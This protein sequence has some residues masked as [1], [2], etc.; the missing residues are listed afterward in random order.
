[1]PKARIP[2]EM[3]INNMSVNA[4]QNLIDCP[5][6]FFL[7]DILKLKSLDT[8][9]N[10]GT[11]SY[12]NFAHKVLEIFHNQNNSD[13]E[14]PGPFLEK[15]TKTNR[16]AAIKHMQYIA[17]YLAL[18]KSNPDIY[19]LH[20]IQRCKK[21]SP[22]YVDWLISNY[23]EK[24][25]T[26]TEKKAQMRISDDLQLIGRIDRII[27]KGSVCKIIDYKT[28]QIPT[29]NDCENGE[30]VQ[31][32]SYALYNDHVEHA[33]YLEIKDNSVKEKNILKG[34]D[35]LEA[36]ELTKNR[37]SDI[38]GSILAGD[39]L[40]ANGDEKACQ[41]CDMSGICRKAYWSQQ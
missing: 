33:A 29:A 5:Y 19:I 38:M 31:L 6:K 7:K 10:Q 12:G 13:K 2:K 36:K 22:Y 41:Y 11:V 20:N 39:P 18:K 8:S 26:E 21:F 3:M 30:S 23:N 16:K 9:Q 35:L 15:F 34:D 4:H 28:G 37:L 32:A 40:P 24:Y 25:I 17:E 1:M 27:Q 14:S